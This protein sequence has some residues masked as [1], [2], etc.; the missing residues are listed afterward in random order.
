MVLACCAFSLYDIGVLQPVIS[1]SETTTPIITSAIWEYSF[2]K[3]L[4][5][6][7]LGPL[8]PYEVS[9]IVFFSIFEDPCHLHCFEIGSRPDTH[10]KV[11]TTELKSGVRPRDK[12]FRL[13]RTRGFWWVPAH[14]T[15]SCLG[16]TPTTEVAA[17]RE[18]AGITPDEWG[19]DAVYEQVVPL[20][21]TPGFGRWYFDE[22]SGRVIVPPLSGAE[23]ETMPSHN[24]SFM[25][26]DLM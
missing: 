24:T 14:R 21:S 12:S 1:P 9:G 26:L 22:R 16:W 8:V 10:V 20:P 15:S 7:H 4:R 6:W 17:A 23:S 11:T 13:D 5:P 2:S 3:I 25:V 18:F 19:S